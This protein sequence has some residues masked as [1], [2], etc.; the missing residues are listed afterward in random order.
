MIIETCPKCGATLMNYVI[1]TYPPIS[2]KKCL[3]CGWLWEE[4]QTPI[5][6]VRFDPEENQN[7]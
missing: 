7:V 3:K 6:T 4:K 5:I 2:A 1:T